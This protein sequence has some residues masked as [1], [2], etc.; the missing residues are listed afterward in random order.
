[1]TAPKPFVGS[2]TALDC[3][4]KCP[5]QFFHR[6]IAKDL[7]AQAQTPEMAWGNE[8]HTAFEQ[9]IGGKPLPDKM[10]QWEGFVSPILATGFN[11]SAES[12]LGITRNGQRCSFFDRDVWFR[13]KV[14]AVMSR[15]ET[16]LI[17]DWKTGKSAFEHPLELETSAM[18]LQAEIPHY[19]K[20]K[21]RYIWLKENR[22]GQMYDLSDGARTWAKVRELMLEIESLMGG[23]RWEKRSTGL[24]GWCPVKTCPN[25][26]ERK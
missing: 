19:K 3:F 9:R 13:G 15:G 11:T 26:R 18:L 20:I 16:A 7:P 24:C 6:Y 12:K 22:A 5:E 14:D 8:V 21:G 25:W 1:M 10:Q 23:T 4:I 17:V 2:F